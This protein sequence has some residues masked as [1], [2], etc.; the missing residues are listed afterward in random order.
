MKIV[1]TCS[2][3]VSPSYQVHVK[4]CNPISLIKS[5]I[6]AVAMISAHIFHSFSLKSVLYEIAQAI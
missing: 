1:A 5:R 6:L 3:S 2:A 4:V